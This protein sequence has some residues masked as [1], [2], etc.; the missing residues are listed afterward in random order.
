MGPPWYR[1]NVLNLPRWNISIAISIVYKQI[2]WYFTFANHSGKEFLFSTANK[3]LDGIL[4][5]SWVSLLKLKI[6]VLYVKQFLNTPW[7]ACI[8]LLY[9]IHVKKIYSI[10]IG[11][12]QFMCNT[13]AKSVKPV[14]IANR[15]SRL[16][17]TERQQE[18]FKDNDI[19]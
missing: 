15:N 16:W 5:K 19:T 6:V 17:L 3:S 4:M 18:I 11:W 8:V 9:N 12:E 10:L 2:F 14:Q 1:A 13:S 7:A